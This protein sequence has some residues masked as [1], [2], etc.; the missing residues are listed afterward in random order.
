VIRLQV[1]GSVDL[2]SAEGTS[3]DHVLAQPKRT[4]LLA[5]LAVAT[6]RGFH[7]RDV[8]RAMFWPEHDE[9]QAR[10]A[11]RQGLYFLRRATNPGV[12]V[13]R[14]EEVAVSPR[15]LTCDVWDLER[16]LRDDRHED[17]VAIYRGDLLS[18]FHV[19][20]A[21]EFERWL[22]AERARLRACAAAAAWAAA[23]THES[24]GDAAAAAQWARRAAG[25][26]PGDETGLRRLLLYLERL[27]D[28]AAALRAYDAF[29]EE[30]AREYELEPGAE[31][32][33]LADRLR[34][35]GITAGDVTVSP[36]LPAANNGIL[37]AHSVS[38]GV[39]AHSS[40]N[41]LE[42]PGARGAGP[43]PHRPDGARTGPRPRT[44][45]WI[46]AIIVALIVVALGAW[47]TLL[48]SA[49][50]RERVIVAD[51]S[52]AAGDSTVADLVAHLLRTELARSPTL[53]VVGQPTID[54]AL[55]RMRLRPPV[56][57]SPVLAR[58][59]A[60]REEITIVVEGHA[61]AVG[62]GVALSASVIDVASGDILFGATDTAHDR[63]DSRSLL[64]AVGRLG[65]AIRR[66]TGESVAAAS[67]G[68]TL[69]SFTTLSTLALARHMAATRAFWRGDY[70]DA[71]QSVGEAVAIDPEFAHAYL[72][73]AS[74][75]WRARLPLGPA[76]RA[77]DR[78]Y[79]LRSNLTPRER[80]TVEGNYHNYVTGDIARAVE[81][82]RRHVEARQKGEGVWYQSY[83]A[84]L[85][86][87]GDLVRAREVLDESLAFYATADSRALHVAVLVALAD[88]LE[89]ERLLK[90]SLEAHPGHPRLLQASARLL[91]MRGAWTEA[92][93]QA[94][95]IRHDGG[96]EN[97]LLTMAVLDA[98]VG[99]FDE[100]RL[101]L[102]A[103]REQALTLDA[104]PAAVEISC[105]LGELRLVA[106]HPQ[107]TA[108]TEDLLRDYPITSI[109]TLSRPYLP[110]ALLYARAGRTSE[111]R[112]WLD[113]WERE[114]PE[115]FRGPHRLLHHR[116][117]AA[118]H[119][120]K[121]GPDEAVREL[122]QAGRMPVQVG[123]FDDPFI[124]IGNHP[125]LA[126][127]YDHL[128]EA[129]SA[130]A[131][132]GR[133]LSAPSLDRSVIDAFEL[134]PALERLAQLYEARGDRQRAA[135]TL[136][137]LVDQ[138]R[139]ADADLQ[140]R[141]LHARRRADM[142]RGA[143]E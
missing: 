118:L 59:V 53:S 123:M 2:A 91:A 86:A 73:L 98:V 92:H 32:R 44:V 20:D 133:Y 66:G 60:K 77:L 135:A 61:D 45:H 49:P 16:A 9:D 141:V 97:D 57:L 52:S 54:G 58:D 17:A 109:D 12:I 6:P 56:R 142:L 112:A 90:T 67:P 110:L 65:E 128:G 121:A 127:A 101:H 140:P 85:I 48:R 51:F 19:S 136:V 72:L 120:A 114:Y 5:W 33:R 139:D 89:A 25:F 107:P 64:P 22:D 79:A 62:S 129:D 105:A 75:Q 138:W 42:R 35:T 117:R 102:L 37:R 143:P 106:G 15:H 71:A 81:A 31:T 50:E 39:T 38:D 122:R 119:L 41:D 55:Q 131:V 124:P 84:S 78:A 7:R 13:S 8:I 94:E 46:P 93:A 23:G 27:G 82:F 28:R 47:W 34:H 63:R 96:L 104:V 21:P 74:M 76:L 125:D 126:R 113:A 40:E 18:G 99:R 14:G 132:Y 88:T 10:H 29:V 137:R 4:A 26:M 95:R 80:Y 115:R 68:D 87:A 1:L 111:A 70:L 24:A 36:S 100:A 103:L 69:W 83:A 30:L 3:L 43:Q 130:I 134:A 116:V 108:D 11:L